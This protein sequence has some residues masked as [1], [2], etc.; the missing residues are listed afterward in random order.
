MSKQEFLTDIQI[1]LARL[2]EAGQT[3]T[4]IHHN[5][6]D[7]LASGAIM[8][9][10][11]HRAGFTVHRIPLER[12]HP[13]IIA[14]IHDQFATPLVYVD[15]GGKAA[16]MISDI[17]QSRRFTLILDHHHPEPATDPQVLNLTTEF[18]GLSG[19]MDISAATAAYLFATI[20]NEKNCDLAYLGVVGALGDLHDRGGKLVGENRL[21]LEQAV[22]LEQVK[23]EQ[24]SGREQYLLTRFG[25]P[26]PMVS[27][28]QSLTTLGAPGYYMDGPALGIK[29]CLEGPFAKAEQKLAELNQIKEVAYQKVLTRLEQDG[30]KQTRYCQWFSVESD[31]V[32]MGVKTI[33][34]FCDEIKDMPI[35]D[36][37]K[38]LVG[39]QIMDG[40][41][42]GLGTFAWNLYKVSM[43]LPTPLEKRVVVDQ[44]MPSLD[45]IVPAA[46]QTVDGSIDACHSYSAAT[47]IP[48]G[49]E[50]ILVDTM[51]ALV[52]QV[53]TLP[54]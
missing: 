50:K 43:R 47:V 28:C 11:L 35:V 14:R 40:T 21:A 27:F 4:L 24:R 20:S 42:P 29:M 2:K 26:V 39:C 31:F 22:F 52:E 33:G 1:G 15:L 10:A 51:D 32:P 18:Y 9:Q 44:T 45:Y 7:G 34:E 13:P 54:S 23:V 19:D 30:F 12:V 38:Y 46:A 25:E 8:Q 17:N 41:I 37:Y 48:I 36:P 53:Q 49:R 6:A 16:P 3:V 5:D